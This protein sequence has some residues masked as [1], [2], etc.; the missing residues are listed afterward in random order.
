M[1][2][3][4]STRSAIMAGLMLTTLSLAQTQSARAQHH[5]TQQHAHQQTQQHA[6]QAQAQYAAYYQQM[7][8]M[9][10]WWHHHHH[11]MAQQSQQ[12]Y[13][14][15]QQQ[16]Q[17]SSGTTPTT[18]S[19]PSTTPST[20]ATTP[21][22]PTTTPSAPTSTPSTSTTTPSTSPFANTYTPPSQG[23]P[24]S[25]SQNSTTQSSSTNHRHH[26]SSS[27]QTTA[28]PQ[29]YAAAA[30][31]QS[32]ADGQSQQQSLLRRGRGASSKLLAA[33]Q[34]HSADPADDA[35]PAKLRV[36]CP[37]GSNDLDQFIDVLDDLQPWVGSAPLHNP[38]CPK[39]WVGSAFLRDLEHDRTA[40][41]ARFSGFV[42]HGDH[43]GP[44]CRRRPASFPAAKPAPEA[45]LYPCSEHAIDEWL[46]DDP[47]A[48]NVAAAAIG[49]SVNQT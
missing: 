38:G 20:P 21:T 36:G 1:L 24:F 17:S 40:N 13:Q 32:T 23:S 49:K 37:A 46:N 5:K 22:A 7:A 44:G 4:P 29:Q 35:R 25:T 34:L 15:W 26:G 47:D 12:S 30:A 31:G 16:S 3:L 2:N 18:P 42:N 8:A 39:L 10:H 43:S 9:Q 33:E 41:D 11:S 27:G 48:S 19:T 45:C 6:Q 28:T 14:Q